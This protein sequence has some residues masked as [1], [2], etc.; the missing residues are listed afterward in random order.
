MRLVENCFH[1][2]LAN[3]GPSTRRFGWTVAGCSVLKL[4]KEPGCEINLVNKSMFHA[5]ENRD[6]S[7]M[8][9]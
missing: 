3:V 2:L 5:F 6:I 4:V 9:R 7:L 1:G 8:A